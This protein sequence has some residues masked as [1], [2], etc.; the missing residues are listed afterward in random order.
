MREYEIRDPSNSIAYP[1]LGAMGPGQ[2][3]HMFIWDAGVS[4]TYSISKWAGDLL[5]RLLPMIIMLW[6]TG[7]GIVVVREFQAINQA[8]PRWCLGQR[9]SLCLPR[10]YIFQSQHFLLF[11]LRTYFTYLGFTNI[12][13]IFVRAEKFRWFI[14]LARVNFTCPLMQ[15]TS[16]DVMKKSFSAPRRAKTNPGQKM[17]PFWRR[18]KAGPFT[19]EKEC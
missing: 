18:Q 6:F 13:T 12:H 19:F 2:P 10:F 11:S 3:Q 4:H 14:I 5:V 1:W 9:S 17:P 7:M 8:A 15:F 16:T